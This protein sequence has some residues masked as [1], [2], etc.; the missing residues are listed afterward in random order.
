LVKGRDIH[1][2]VLRFGFKSGIDVANSLIT[3]WNVVILIQLGLCLIKCLK[4]IGFHGMW[5]LLGVLKTESVCRG[6][7]WFCRMIE[8]PTG[9]AGFD[10]YDDCDYCLWAYRWWHYIRNLKLLLQNVNTLIDNFRS[11]FLLC[12][13]FS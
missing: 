12:N 10:Y 9:W 8:H 3:M 2:H 4:N 6:W 13:T 11:C 5:W 1:F 7:D